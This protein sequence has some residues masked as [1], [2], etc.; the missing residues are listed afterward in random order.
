MSLEETSQLAC[1]TPPPPP[2]G[3]VLPRKGHVRTWQQ[4]SHLQPRKGTLNQEL[5]AMDLDV[6]EPASRTVRKCTSVAICYGSPRRPMRLTL[7]VVL[8]LGHALSCVTL[9]ICWVQV[10]SASPLGCK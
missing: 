8:L 10:A 2:W 6:G 5:T 3:H 7:A 4:S 9:I 1:A